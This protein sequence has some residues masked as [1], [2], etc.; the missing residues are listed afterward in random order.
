MKLIGKVA[1]NKNETGGQR[2]AAKVLQAMYS[3]S[4]GGFQTNKNLFEAIKELYTEEKD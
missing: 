4:D 3:A 2:M 1:S